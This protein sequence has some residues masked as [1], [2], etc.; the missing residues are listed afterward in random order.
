MHRLTTTA[1][2]LGI[3]FTFAGAAEAKSIKH[4]VPAAALANYCEV[5]GLGSET[6]ATITLANGTTLT[7]TVH[8]EAEDLL[9]AGDDDPAAHDLNDDHGGHGAAEAGDDHGSGSDNSGSGG[10]VS[11]S[12]ASGSGHGEHES[13]HGGHGGDD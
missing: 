12:G 5:H 4:D 3:T 8:C 9:V 10:H 6:T 11:G 7:G 13:G 1:L 2:L